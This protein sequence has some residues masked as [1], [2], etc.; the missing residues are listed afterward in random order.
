MTVAATKGFS[1]ALTL[2]MATTVALAQPDRFEPIRGTIRKVIFAKKVPSLAVAVAQNGEI[3]W[4]EAFGFAD[5][6]KQIAATPQT[7]YSLA[8]IS[9]PITATTLMTLV[10]RG[11][12][13]L[14]R[15]IEDYLGG[16]KLKGY[17][18]STS[19]ATVRRIAAHISGL[20]LHYHFFLHGEPSQ[21]PSMAE[22]IRRYGILVTRPGEKFQY[23]NLGYGLLEYAIEQ[24]SQSSYAEFVQENVFEPLGMEHSDIPTEPDP[25]PHRAVRYWDDGMPL[26]FYDF[27]H[28]GGSAVFASAHDLVRFGLLHLKTLQPDQRPVL[29]GRRINQMQK[30]ISTEGAPYEYGVGWMIYPKQG[31]YRLVHHGGAMGGV[32]TNLSLIPSE[33]IAVVVL[34]NRY[35]PV[36]DQINGDILTTLLP[37]YRRRTAEKRTP[38]GKE[39]SAEEPSSVAA[40]AK[41]F[42]KQWT[43]TW[44]GTV[45]TYEGQL[46]LGLSINA[47]GEAKAE[48]AGQAATN[49]SAL[50][51]EGGYLTGRFDGNIQ[52][53][54]VN[55][56]KYYLRFSLKMKGGKLSGA[57][58]A[59]SNPGPKLSNALTSWVEL[60]KE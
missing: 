34:A 43:G 45:H 53:P 13:G 41:P 11:K 1:G 10:E 9:K 21:R 42:P 23:A 46:P 47:S 59:I 36:V 19:K 31:A 6:E 25:G 38:P 2:C 3:L 28:R 4:E 50:K 5:V 35:S 44:S 55:K 51:V 15:P 32:R 33:G 12:I 8:S 14:D 30:S 49:V 7:K 22:T 39:Q 57:L 27:D 56:R 17:A 29:P 24:T 37:R 20:P 52:T 26:P 18:G 54:D 16:A 58:T 60:R 48:L 40:A